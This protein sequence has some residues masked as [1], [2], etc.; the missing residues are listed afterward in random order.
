VGFAAGEL[1]LVAVVDED[2][3]PAAGAGITAAGAVGVDLD[4][5]SA[6]QDPSPCPLPRGERDPEEKG[7]GF[8]DG[9]KS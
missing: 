7:A 9:Q 4:G 3:G 8:A 1:D 5:G 6:T 2:G